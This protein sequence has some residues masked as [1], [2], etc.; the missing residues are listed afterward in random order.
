MPRYNFTKILDNDIEFYEFLRRKRGNIKNL[1]QYGT[2]RMHNPSVGQRIALSTDTHV[3]KYG[4]RYYN[5]SYT[6]YGSVDYWWVIAWYNGYC[7]EADI[8]P[9][10][11]I[12][13]PTDLEKALEALGSY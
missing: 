12:Q 4:D 3:W 6:Y 1:V 10:D 13:I 7:T 11:V 2:T 9:G 8:Y 5:L